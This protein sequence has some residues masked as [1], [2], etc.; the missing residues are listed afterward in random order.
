LAGYAQPTK[1]QRAAA[2]TAS[3]SS[4]R[5]S[6]V[7]SNQTFPAPLVLP[8]DDFNYDPECS[9]QTVHSWLHEK[10]RNKLSTEYDRDTLYIGR[11]PKIGEDVQF[12]RDWT[13]PSLFERDAISPDAQ[14]FV[15]NLNVFYHGMSVE[16]LK[17]P[18]HWT[19]WAQ[20]SR[21]Y[22]SVNLPKHVALAYD[23]Q[24]TRIRVRKALDGIFAA[25]LNLNN[26]IDAAIAMLPDDAY[27]L[28]LL[29]DHDIYKDED[30]DICCGRAYGGSRVA[31]VQTARYNP[32]LDVH[33]KIDHM[34][35]WPFSYCKI[36]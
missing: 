13:T 4:L 10:A 3:G 11:V 32:L 14:R 8:H 2:M 15:D 20:S 5:L 29:V 18:L 19:T 22:R 34:H 16:T 30:D 24:R 1:Q 12:M 23:G 33:G 26:I 27:A 6:N 25:Q 21:A 35:V 31:V 17:N 36:F 7:E 28:L 9:P